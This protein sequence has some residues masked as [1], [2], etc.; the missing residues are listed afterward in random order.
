[1]PMHANTRL[2]SVA[3][4]GLALTFVGTFSTQA[5][6]NESEFFE[7]HVRPILI[8]RCYECHAGKMK[9]GGLSLETPKGWRAGGESGAAI[10]PGKPDES[11]LIE[12]INYRSLEMP[13][14]DKGGK[15]P[16][17][18]IAILT[19]WVSDGAFDPRNSTPRIGGMDREQAMSWWAFQPLPHKSSLTPA[20]IDEHITILQNNLTVAPA[21]DKRTLIRR[22]TYDLTGLPPTAEEVDAWMAD[23][24]AGAFDKVID[25][26]LQSPQYGPQW[27]RHWLDVVRYADTAGENT[28]RPLPHAWRYRNWVI[29]AL[30]R[31]MSFDEFARLQLAGDVLRAEADPDGRAE[32]IIA[33]GYL[34]IARRFGHDIDKDI[35]LMREDVIDN[36]GKSFLGLTISCARCHDHKYDPITSEDY[37]ALYGIFESTRF[38]FPGC[39]PKG[40]PR[41]LIP[42]IEEARVDQLKADYEHKLKA[43]EQQLQAAKAKARQIKE[44][45]AQSFKMIAQAEVAETTTVSI[46]STKNENAI[47]QVEMQRGE[48]LQLTVTPNGGYGADTTLVDWRIV[49]NDNGTEWKTSDLISRFAEGPLI[50]DRGAVWCFL[51]N[52]DG[53]VFLCEQ[54]LNVDHQPSLST[55]STGGLPSVTVNA[56]PDPVSAWT[57]LPGNSF[58]VHPGDQK[59]VAIAWVCPQ[60][61]TY[62]VQ[63]TVAD[64]HPAPGLDGVAFRIEHFASPDVGNNLIALGKAATSS[65]TAPP[66]PPMIPVAYGVAEAEPKNAR[67]QQ[68]GEPEQLG[69][70]VP[71]RWLSAFGGEAVSQSGSGR[72]ELAAWIVQHPLF[73][74]VIVNRVWQWHFGRGLVASPNDFG[75]RGEP[76]THPALLDELAAYFQATGYRLKPLHRLIMSTAAYQ[77]SSITTSETMASDPD[78]RWLARFTRR[79]LTAEEIRDSL[80]TASGK[81]DVSPGEAHPFPPESTWSFTQHAPFNAV[82]ETSRR[83]V[84][85]MVQRQRRHP[86]LALFDG[87]DPNSSTATRQTTTGPTQAL[88]F[89]NN[90][91]FY[92]QAEGVAELITQQPDS[93]RIEF[94]FQYLFQRPPQANELRIAKQFIASYPGETLDKWAAYARVLLASN[95]FLYVD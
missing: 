12:A 28:D 64:A 68:R 21:A 41:D 61:G 42:L 86:Y 57:R 59:T 9:R 90:P 91:F 53:P 32:G 50:R 30:N 7:K 55:W 11:L 34:A 24:S 85:M 14:P 71:R 48:V 6:E 1:M 87:A 16:S 10:V 47:N 84:F 27:G 4:F 18:E 15:L 72:E 54:K 88:Y 76:P 45:A 92:E 22:A 37:Y 39:E 29:E 43:R 77:R 81:L 20:D 26:L 58:F 65:A 69:D 80:L 25:R 23:D 83:S 66:E 78:N 44:L 56:S 40:Q 89:L 95:E 93:K 79:R 70:E 38:S 74:R 13:P 67:L 60:D 52:T 63:G 2:I 31:D 75:S 8:D 73:A 3:A 19:K 62:H 35:H 49:R 82:Y 51:D 46:A 17:D 36:V 33:T 94:A 5:D